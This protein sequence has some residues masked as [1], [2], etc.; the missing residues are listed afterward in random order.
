MPLRGEVWWA[1]LDPVRGSEIGKTRLC[2]VLTSDILNERR[3]TLV[4]IP[5]STSPKP[6]P[7]LLIPVRCAGRDAVAVTDQVRAISKE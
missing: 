7:P 2:V 4:V 1:R 5:L 6:N 3:R